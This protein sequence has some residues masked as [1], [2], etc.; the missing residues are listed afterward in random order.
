MF[1]IPLLMTGISLK[2]IEFVSIKW[3]L[4]WSHDRPQKRPFYTTLFI[5]AGIWFEYSLWSN[6]SLQ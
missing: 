2:I 1:Y 6:D 4:W 5:E 3:P